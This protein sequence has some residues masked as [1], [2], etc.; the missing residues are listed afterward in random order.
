MANYQCN[1]C[2]ADLT[3]E[4]RRFYGN[5]CDRCERVELDQVDDWRQGL[6][7]APGLMS[8]YAESET[9]QITG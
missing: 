8:S 1:T 9:E 5:T 6:A 7:E 4:E 2:G 3:R